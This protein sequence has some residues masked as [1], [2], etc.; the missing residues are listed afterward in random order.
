MKTHV[1]KPNVRTWAKLSQQDSLKIEHLLWITEKL[2]FTNYI[3][4]FTVVSNDVHCSHAG[5]KKI[6][7]KYLRLSF[8]I[9]KSTNI[10][11]SDT[12]EGNRQWGVIER[13]L[14]FIVVCRMKSVG[15]IS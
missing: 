15:G 10:D 3:P 6:E 12:Y 7:V 1:D 4:T 8:W 11:K 14:S 2:A 5:G 9:Q 13:L